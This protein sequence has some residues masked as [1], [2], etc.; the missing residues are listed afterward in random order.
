MDRASLWKVSG[1]SE[2][3]GE[4]YA[5]CLWSL[6][7]FAAGS[8]VNILHSFRSQCPVF[9]S[10]HWASTRLTSRMCS[11]RTTTVTPVSLFWASL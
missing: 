4:S 1:G 7:I 5:G 9:H 2:R 10:A 3:T 8:Q 6:K 11:S